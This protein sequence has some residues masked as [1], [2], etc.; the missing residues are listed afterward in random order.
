MGERLP[1]DQA[2]EWGLINR[3]YEDADLM[4]E[5]RKLAAELAK[6]PFSLGLIRKLLWD[7]A[8]ATYEEQ[9]NNERWAQQTAG[10]SGDFVEGVSAFGEKRPPTLKAN[11]FLPSH[12]LAA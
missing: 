1:A 4:D 7:S 5:A 6:G 9:L 12:F 11:N 3:V 10:R 8:D 2:L